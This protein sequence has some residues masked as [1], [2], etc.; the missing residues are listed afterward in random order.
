MLQVDVDKRWDVNALLRHSWLRDTS[1]NIRLL[2]VYAEN[3]CEDDDFHEE[4]L[5][6]EIKDI[7]IDDDEPC[8]QQ[9]KR[10]RLC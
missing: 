1:V 5:M 8:Q 3:S 9:A 2:E 6:K 4:I 7:I 10:L